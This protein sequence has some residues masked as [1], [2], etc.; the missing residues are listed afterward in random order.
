[1]APPSQQ[2]AEP[3][4]AANPHEMSVHRLEQV[5]G[6]IDTMSRSLD[7]RVN[8]GTI[9]RA[10]VPR[11]IAGRTRSV[12]RSARHGRA[13]RRR[14]DGRRATRVESGTGCGIAAVNR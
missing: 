3:S 2:L 5:D 6:H 8:Q 12:T 10:R 14:P 7:A 9:R 13:A 1:M 4:H 11:C